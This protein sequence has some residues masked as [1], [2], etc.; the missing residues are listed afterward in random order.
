MPT[1]TTTIERIAILETKVV[2]L[3][4]TITSLETKI[5][6]LL[7]IKNKGAGAFWLA[8]LLFG[9]GIVGF[10]SMVVDWVKTHV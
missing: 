3:E 8:S 1:D 5:D 7:S 4:T 9:T 10:F 6:A 2:S